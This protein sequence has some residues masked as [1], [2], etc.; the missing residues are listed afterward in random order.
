MDGWIDGREERRK[1][2]RKEGWMFGWMDGWIGHE[3]WVVIP[4][5]NEAVVTSLEIRYSLQVF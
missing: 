1:K 5:F 2:G 4:S 3:R